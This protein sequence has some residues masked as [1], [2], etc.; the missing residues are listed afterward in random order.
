MLSPFTACPQ[1][2]LGGGDNQRLNSSGRKMKRWSLV[3]VLS[4]NLTLLYKV[5][6]PLMLHEFCISMYARICTHLTVV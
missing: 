4:C 3:A 1:E 2:W 5:C 6:M